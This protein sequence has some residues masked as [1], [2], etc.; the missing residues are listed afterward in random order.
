MEGRG[1]FVIYG[2]LFLIVSFL[3]FSQ[4]SVNGQVDQLNA[5]LQSLRASAPPTET[6]TPTP[7]AAPSARPSPT[8]DL[9]TA[10]ARDAKRK[11]DLEAIK[12]SL[13]AY[14]AEKGSYP[15]SLSILGSVPQDPLSP[16]YGYRYT[17]A[18]P[19]G[20]R[21]TCVLETKGD[22]DDGKDG[23]KDQVYTLTDK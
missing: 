6:G 20:F 22:A 7:S 5:E 23:R 3:F 18:I 2:V 13:L 11:E 14:Q 12:E 17:R 4:L 1:W 9:S 16:K 19:A 15:A 21:L 10:T 8:P